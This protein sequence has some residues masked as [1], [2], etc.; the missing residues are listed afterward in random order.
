MI[1]HSS[2]PGN[3]RN[4]RNSWQVVLL[5][6]IILFPSFLYSEPFRG[7]NCAA[8]HAKIRDAKPPET[9]PKPLDGGSFD[10]IVIGGGLSGLT[11]AHFLKDTNVL[12]LEKEDHVGGR[13]R[14]DTLRAGM[15]PVGAV[16]TNEAYGAI[17]TLMTDLKVVFQPIKLQNSMYLSTGSYVNDWMNA[18]I[19]LLAYSDDTKTK[20]KRL[21]DELIQL[22]QTEALAIPVEHSKNG[23]LRLYDRVTF[24]KY[25]E[26]LYGPEI[27][28]LGDFYSRDVFGITSVEISAFAGLMYMAGE[29]EPTFTG[30]GGIGEISEA[31]GKEMKEHIR[32]GSFVWQV[33]Q[34]ADAATVLY[35]RG[36]KTYSATA[37]AVV[38]AVPSMV[39]KKIAAD[40]TAPKRRALN[41]VRYSAYALVPMSLTKP[42]VQDTFVLWNPNAYFTD[43]T[44][45]AQE[46]GKEGQVVVA[47]VPFGGEPGRRRL[48]NTSDATIRLRV[49]QD[50]EKMFPGASGDIGEIG[51]IRWGHAMPVPAP[52]YMLKV[53]PVVARPEGRYFF[54]GVDTQ[55]PCL[56]GAVY[57][58]FIAAQ[59]VR[60]FLGLSELTE[61]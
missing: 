40:L 42:L 16:Y 33:K 20:L 39:T 7:E 11:A 44:F 15:T 13:I 37:K 30:I 9:A 14:R 4:S 12:L 34:E 26:D 49:T 56:E 61:E 41:A 28:K 27:A 21:R 47:Y 10:V 52:D 46:P 43:L 18:G 59:K 60:K 32:T 58:G 25:L 2:S 24:H 22:N 54:A 55:L 29:L 53:R 31:V 23:P 45:P 57:S 51:V 48:F 8:C 50:I 6:F 5:S 19:D 36:G 17:E 1:P 3:S 38:W 35:D